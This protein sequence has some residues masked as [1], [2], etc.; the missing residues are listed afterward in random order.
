MSL[1]RIRLPGGVLFRR[2]RGGDRGGFGGNERISPGCAGHRGRYRLATAG[3]GPAV[4]AVRR[5][6][7][8]TRRPCGPGRKSYSYRSG[9]YA[10]RCDTP[11]ISTTDSAF[12]PFGEGCVGRSVTA[13]VNDLDETLTA[14][15]S[16]LTA[17][18]QRGRV[19]DA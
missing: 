13:G 4:C 5:A 8:P 7:E 19:G 17:L 9:D 6:Y 12:V 2:M 14:A 18:M 11:A 3:D 1:W 16:V 15:L 10:T